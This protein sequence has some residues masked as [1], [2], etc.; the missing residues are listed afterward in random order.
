MIQHISALAHT[1]FL[2]SIR[3][4]VLYSVLFFAA[5]LVG[6]SALFGAVTIGDQ[7]VVIKDFGLMA[8][9]LMA[10]GFTIITGTNLLHKELFRKTIYNVLSKS[11]SRTSFILGKYLGLLATALSISCLMSLG[12]EVFIVPFQ[13]SIDGPV[14]V[15]S[16]YIALELIM[17]CAIALFFSTIVVTPFLSGLFT[18]GLFLAGRS[19][20]YIL[21]LTTSSTPST[22]GNY[23][24]T[25][26][27]YLLPHFSKLNVANDA[28][29]GI[30][31]SSAH[32][33]WA[34]IYSCGYAAVVLT[35]ASTIFSHR[36]FNQ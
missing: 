25:A 5:A 6:V 4:K 22:F 3:S 30:V 28:A 31:P 19:A 21:T 35:I 13:G 36:D 14:A 16:F 33:A 1:T 23:L 18:F 27:Y 9:S 26:L 20:D 17:L 7:I 8:V 11:V 10:T 12:L 29:Y 15:A 2:E 32:L 24:L 34:V